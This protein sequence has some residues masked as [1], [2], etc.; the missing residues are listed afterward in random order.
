MHIETK[1][2]S[3]YWTPCVVH[4]LNLALKN[5]CVAKICERNSDT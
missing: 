5:I 1:F 2:P 4:T 3:I